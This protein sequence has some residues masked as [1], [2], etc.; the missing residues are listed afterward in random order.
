MHVNDTLGDRWM[1][2]TAGGW[3]KGLGRLTID[4]AVV[5]VVV[6]W[7]YSG[8]DWCAVV[9]SG[10]VS[11]AVVAIADLGYRRGGGAGLGEWC[12]KSPQWC[13]VEDTSESGAMQ[14][15]V[16]GRGMHDLA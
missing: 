1:S 14:I 13:V 12:M 10:L 3:A 8:V 2:G 7:S 6:Q 9:C 15:H 11:A 16:S 5:A 4:C